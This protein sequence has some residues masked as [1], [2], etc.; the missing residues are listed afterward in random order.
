MT[1]YLSMLGPLLKK[2]GTK[3]GFVSSGRGGRVPRARI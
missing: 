2:Y 3:P 1:D